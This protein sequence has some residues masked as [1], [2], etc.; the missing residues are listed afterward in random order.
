MEIKVTRK[1]QIN[2]VEMKKE[3]QPSFSFPPLPD[4]PALCTPLWRLH[5]ALK[6]D[7]AFITVK[8]GN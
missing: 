7:C 4:A 6:R 8:S 5:D 3:K 1:K 2:V